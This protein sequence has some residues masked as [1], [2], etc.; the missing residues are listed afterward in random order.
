MPHKRRE[1]RADDEASDEGTLAKE[2]QSALLIFRRLLL[3]N[4]RCVP[5]LALLLVAG[6]VIYHYL[7][8]RVE[9]L[10]CPAI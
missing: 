6:A 4:P 3:K 10:P 7:D 8:F 5:A 2:R 9:L 1:R